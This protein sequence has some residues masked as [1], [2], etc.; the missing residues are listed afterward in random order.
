[1][2]RFCRQCLLREMDEKEAFQNLYTY[3]EHLPSDDKVPDEVY[4]ERLNTCKGCS[5]LLSG[6]CRLCGCYVELRAAMKVRG[7]PQ[8]P[9]KWEPYQS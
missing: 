2:Q 3:L 6:M 5:Q 8:L 9:P 4:E 7:C 1:M